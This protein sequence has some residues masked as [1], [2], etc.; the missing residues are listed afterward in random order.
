[1]TRQVR[2]RRRRRLPALLRRLPLLSPP[3]TTSIVPTE[4]KTRFG[5]LREDLEFL[6]EWLVPRFTE[7]DL[8]AQREQN[9][10]RRQQLLLVAAGSLGAVLGAVQAALDDAKWPGLLL[11]LVAVL[12]AV[13]AQ[14]VQHGQALPRY[15]DERAKAER[16]RSVYFQYVVRVDRYQGPNRRQRLREDVAALVSEKAS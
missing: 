1:M 5:D 3:T 11:S 12:S 2:A 14:Q 16:L 6:D 15:L 4:A 10:H 13:F 9:R 8:K 7:C